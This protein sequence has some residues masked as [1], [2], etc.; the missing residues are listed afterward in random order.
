VKIGFRICLKLLRSGA[1][2]IVTTRFPHDAAR[3][4]AAVADAEEWASRLHV[5]GLDLRDINGIEQFV[6][7]VKA[8]YVVC[9]VLL[10]RLRFALCLGVVAGEAQCMCM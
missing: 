10:L 7:F 6:A 5:Y 8:K 4:Y 2:V 9:G 1:S 3:R